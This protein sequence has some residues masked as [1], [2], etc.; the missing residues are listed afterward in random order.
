MAKEVSQKH[1]LKA[2]D[3]TGTSVTSDTMKYYEALKGDLKTKRSRE[4]ES[5]VYG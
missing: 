4:I 5:P 2:I 1:F 3:E